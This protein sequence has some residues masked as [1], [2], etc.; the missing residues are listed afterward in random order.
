MTQEEITKLYKEDAGS[1]AQDLIQ[2]LKEKHFGIENSSY[3]NSLTIFK[4]EKLII[5]VSSNG[6]DF[7]QE[8]PKKALT[9]KEIDNWILKHIQHQK[10]E[11]PKETITNLGI[12][13]AL[14]HEFREKLPRTDENHLYKLPQLH[15][16]QE[17]ANRSCQRLRKA[18]KISYNLKKKWILE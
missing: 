16:A 12:G 8:I 15:N 11:F 14:I 7:Y 13:Y 6:V 1:N 4:H 17:L 18:G 2:I 5:V 10:K 3:D 9:I